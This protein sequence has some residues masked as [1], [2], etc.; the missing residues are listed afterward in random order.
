MSDGIRVDV[1]YYNTSSDW[2]FE[3]EL[4]SRYYNLRLLSACISTKIDLLKSLS[5]AVSRS[6]TI[7]IVGGWDREENIP[8]TVAKSVGLTCQRVGLAGSDP[9]DAVVLPKGAK[10]FAHGGKIRCA[11]ISRGP[12]AIILVDDEREGRAALAK[13]FI[14][15]YLIKKAGLLPDTKEEIKPKPQNAPSAALK[16][17]GEI[18]AKTPAPIKTDTESAK[19]HAPA[20]KRVEPIGE[21][22]PVMPTKA[23]KPL[24]ETPRK[25]PL[26]QVDLK[27]TFFKNEKSKKQDA[28]LQQQKNELADDSLPK[29]D[30]NQQAQ[31][32]LQVDRDIADQPTA[33]DDEFD[34]GIKLSVMPL[35]LK[36]LLAF[37]LL[38]LLFAALYFGYR[39]FASGDPLESA[40]YIVQTILNL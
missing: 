24:E 14:A 25:P 23:A 20:Q 22:L 11:V 10:P 39:D 7:I 35:P 9:K 36:I 37:I 1:I 17:G 13:R 5:R 16:K 29:P 40:E 32:H 26:P 12:Q 30:L 2:L 31:P 27:K 4:Y 19:A 3:T 28:P 8:A 18:T 38:A 21:S 33:E 15:P 6:E 34:D